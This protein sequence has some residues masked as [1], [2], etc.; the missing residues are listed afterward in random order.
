M[1]SWAPKWPRPF[2]PLL[3]NTDLSM[4]CS[5]CA[6]I[7]SFQANCEN[8]SR[9]RVRRYARYERT[10]KYRNWGYYCKL[11]IQ[12]C[13]G[14]DDWDIVQKNDASVTCIFR[15]RNQ[16]G[17]NG[18]EISRLITSCGCLVRLALS[19]IRKLHQKPRYHPSWLA[20]TVGVS[21]SAVKC[22]RI[23]SLT[24]LK[25]WTPQ[26]FRLKI[27]RTKNKIPVRLLDTFAAVRQRWGVRI[28]K[29]I[30]KSIPKFLRPVVGHPC[31]NFS[32]DI[33]LWVSYCH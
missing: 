23:V 33:L 29:I 5:F 18:V 7:R 2:S 26:F 14:N 8:A 19:R 9:I 27:A 10:V 3:R 11:H 31:S 25:C 12:N 24:L 15:G 20:R 28:K 13:D 17:F 16:N 4:W 21:K 32:N 1:L 30:M 6:H 22:F